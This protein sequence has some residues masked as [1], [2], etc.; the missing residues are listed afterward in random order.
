MRGQGLGVLYLTLGYYSD[1]TC[2]SIIKGL[3]VQA[4]SDL[5][6]LDSQGVA[7]KLKAIIAVA[8]HPVECVADVMGVAAQ[9]IWRWVTA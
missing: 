6:I 1:S 8:K 3:A 5:S 4:Q 9:T 7:V 2:C